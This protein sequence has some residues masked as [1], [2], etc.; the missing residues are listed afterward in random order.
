[1]TE[2]DAAT[3]ATHL[4]NQAP[5]P[6]T[7]DNWDDISEVTGNTGSTR[8]SK[9]ARIT[10]DALKVVQREHHLA[11]KEQAESFALKFE[12][13]E[14]MKAQ[15]QQLQDQTTQHPSAN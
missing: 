12:E 9:A 1:M 7:H 5:K 3:L 11:L 10:E 4:E 6:V 2:D 14:A 15:F 8:S 13:F